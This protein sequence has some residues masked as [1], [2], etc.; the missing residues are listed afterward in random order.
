MWIRGGVAALAAR[1]EPS[2]GWMNGALALKRWTS[3][4]WMVAPCSCARA[5]TADLTAECRGR[6]WLHERLHSSRRGS[7]GKTPRSISR[8]RVCV[9]PPTLGC[10]R[11]KGAS[12]SHK[13][14]HTH[15]RL[16]SQW[17]HGYTFVLLLSCI[18]SHLRIHTH[19]HLPAN[20]NN[21]S[22]RVRY[23]LGF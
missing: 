14:K 10:G 17:R 21:Q 9:V 1:S 18:S 13:G 8:A 5:L 23:L 2:S 20:K 22:S 3:L 4:G 7:L 16:Y 19:A 15:I 12:Q 6:V 11:G